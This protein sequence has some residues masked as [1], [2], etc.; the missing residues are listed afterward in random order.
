MGWNGK[1]DVDLVVVS[2]FRLRPT[3]VSTTGFGC[4]IMPVKYEK[5]CTFSVEAVLLVLL[6]VEQYKSSGRTCRCRWS[7]IFAQHC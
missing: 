4:D 2:C 7:S 3:F 6:R 5:A 1:V